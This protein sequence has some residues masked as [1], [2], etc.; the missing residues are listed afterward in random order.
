MYRTSE[1]IVKALH[2]GTTTLKSIR[3][4]VSRYRKIQRLDCVLIYM[5]AIETYL[6]ETAQQEGEMDS[7]Y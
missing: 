4:S 1:E 6:M 7:K 5:T 3:N 2:Q